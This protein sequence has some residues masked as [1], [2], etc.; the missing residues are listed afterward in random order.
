MGLP[1]WRVVRASGQLAAGNRAEQA[2][3][4]RREGVPVRGDRVRRST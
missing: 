2:R 3:R 4:L 1:W